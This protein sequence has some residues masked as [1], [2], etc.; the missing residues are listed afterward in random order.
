MNIKESNYKSSKS[1][2]HTRLAIRNKVHKN[3]EEGILGNIKRILGNVRTA[4]KAPIRDEQGKLTQKGQ[5][6]SS[7]IQGGLRYTA[8]LGATTKTGALIPTNIPTPQSL[9][10]GNVA[11]S[12]LR[13]ASGSAQNL[14]DKSKSTEGN[15]QIEQPTKDSI[16]VIPQVGMNK[17]KE[18]N[19]GISD[20]PITQIRPLLDLNKQLIS[21]NLE[22]ISTLEKGM[23]PRSGLFGKIADV[24]T[25]TRAQRAAARANL[26]S[27]EQAKLK[28]SNLERQRD[29]LRTRGAELRRIRLGLPKRPAELDKL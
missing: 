10:T 15:P 3:L 27:L 12:I 19:V 26:S 6:M 11:K 23:L 13:M 17:G 7:L 24:L 20:I 14:S 2:R 29:L 22:N 16:T 21:K 1:S 5:L 8:G 25:R 28:A 18:T 4:I 9:V